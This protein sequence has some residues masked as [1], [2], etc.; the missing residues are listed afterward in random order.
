MLDVHPP[1]APTHTWR[2]F[3]IHIATIVVGLLIAVG[4]E[5]TVEFFHHRHEV[6]ETREALRRE[7]ENNHR[8]YAF[9]A[10]AF[11]YVAG[12]LANDALVFSYLK[13]HPGTPMEKLPGTLRWQF[14]YLPAEDVAWKAAQQ[15]GITAFMPTDEVSANQ[16][17]YQ[18]M[19]VTEAQ[20]NPLWAALGKA[21][22]FS[23]IDPDPSHMSPAQLETELDLLSAAMEANYHWG[24]LMAA[25]HGDFPEFTPAPS[26]A[27]LR[28]LLAPGLNAQK[29][30]L[31][32]PN[33]LSDARLAALKEGYD[34]AGAENAPK[35]SQG[36]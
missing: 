8:V 22:Q 17:L 11:R 12:Q 34:K 24:L 6:K 21:Q 14:E 9:N 27:E 7:R 13:Q 1:H 5:Q 16:Y 2:D 28:N 19:A 4:L 20:V 30:T 31:T 36:R 29:D 35:V 10:A 3:L 26:P 33:A 15:N 23:H 18:F 32:V 25:Q